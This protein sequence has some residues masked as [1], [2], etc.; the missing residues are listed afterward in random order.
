MH[1]GLH[2]RGASGVGRMSC[3]GGATAPRQGGS[4]VGRRGSHTR[5]DVFVPG[6][7][8]VMPGVDAGKR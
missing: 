7:K 8:V 6:D 5:E 1:H 4:R 2:T 3:R